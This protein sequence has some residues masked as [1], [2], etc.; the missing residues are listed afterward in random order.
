MG[1]AKS[2]KTGKKRGFVELLSDEE[3]E[4]D[5]KGRGKQMQRKPTLQDASATIATASSDTAGTNRQRKAV[6]TV[7][8]A[9]PSSNSSETTRE[10]RNSYGKRQKVSKICKENLERDD[11]AVENARPKESADA[12]GSG[13]NAEKSGGMIPKKSAIK[14][15]PNTVPPQHSVPKRCLSATSSS[16]KKVRSKRPSVIGHRLGGSGSADQDVEKI[17]DTPAKAATN[18]AGN[19]VA[20]RGKL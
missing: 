11:G 13:K 2:R 10:H 9:T 16:A 7:P 4:T 20:G 19:T 1:M 6:P 17:N 8:P 18:N 12:R 14:Q 5:E 15:D 3:E